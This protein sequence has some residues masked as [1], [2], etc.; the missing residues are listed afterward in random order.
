[1]AP[2]RRNYEPG[3]PAFIVAMIGGRQGNQIEKARQS[4][5]TGKTM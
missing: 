2:E 5:E 4:P 3:R 1:M